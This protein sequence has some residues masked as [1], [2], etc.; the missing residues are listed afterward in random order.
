MCKSRLFSFFSFLDFH[1]KRC[2]DRATTVDAVVGPG[3][4]P[5]VSAVSKWEYFNGFSEVNWWFVN[6][7]VYKKMKAIYYPDRKSFKNSKNRNENISMVSPRSI[8]GLSIQK[9]IKNKSNLHCRFLVPDVAVLCQ[10]WPSELLL[11]SAKKSA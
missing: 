9:S 4:K 8:D 2:M 11:P 1:C 6:P 7:E 10:R 5:T 3:R